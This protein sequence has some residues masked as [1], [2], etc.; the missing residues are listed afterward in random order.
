MVDTKKITIF[1]LTAGD[2]SVTVPS[3]KIQFNSVDQSNSVNF[4]KNDNERAY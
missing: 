2:A 4:K 3:D 1:R